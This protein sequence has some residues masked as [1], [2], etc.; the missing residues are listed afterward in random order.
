[1]GEAGAALVEAGYMHVALCGPVSQSW[2]GFCRGL[3]L[4]QPQSGN[5]GF[6]HSLLWYLV[7]ETK[8]KHHQVSWRSRERAWSW[9]QPS[10][11]PHQRLK[12]ST[13]ACP[14]AP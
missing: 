2:A 9:A 10:T 3:A 4:L 11:L 8:T 1:M 7:Q 13:P 6:R 5:V 14:Q 12:G